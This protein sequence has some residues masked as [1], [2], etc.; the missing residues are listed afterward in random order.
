LNGEGLGIEDA[1]KSIELV[2]KIRKEEINPENIVEIHP[3]LK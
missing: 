2:Y 3:F 1:R